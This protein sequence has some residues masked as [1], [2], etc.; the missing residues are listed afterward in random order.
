MS[1][2]EIQ[3]IALSWRQMITVR[4]W[5]AYEEDLKKEGW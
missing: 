4:L 5:P 1:Q 2:V 3:T